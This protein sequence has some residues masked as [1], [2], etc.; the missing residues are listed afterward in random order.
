[1]LLDRG[2]NVNA[3]DKDKR[4]ALDCARGNL[5]LTKILLPHKADVHT[6]DKNGNTPLHEAT[7]RSDLELMK[8]LL[9]H[10][11][12]VNARTSLDSTP[13]HFLYRYGSDSVEEAKILLEHGANPNLKGIA[14]FL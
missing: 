3:R 5:E 8:I 12:D 1:M 4:T 13:L 11:A 9:A 6:E 14:N 2:A 7:R 10:K